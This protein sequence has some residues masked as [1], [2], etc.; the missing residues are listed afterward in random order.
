MKRFI[1]FIISATIIL[2]LFSACS[3][4]PL[5]K[6]QDKVVEIGND[7]LDYKITAKEAIEKLDSIIVPK[8]DNLHGATVLEC[9]ISILRTMLLKVDSGFGD[10]SFEEISEKVD[11]IDNKDLSN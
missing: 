1:S 7:F 5:E 3:S 8:D 10:V 11:E 4:S 6:A 9:Y 2:S